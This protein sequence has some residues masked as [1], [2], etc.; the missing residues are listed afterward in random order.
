MGIN[1]SNKK[2][3]LEVEKAIRTRSFVEPKKKRSGG[4][5]KHFNAIRV[6]DSLESTTTPDA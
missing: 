6:G 4:K 5:S 3:M 1:R 2:N